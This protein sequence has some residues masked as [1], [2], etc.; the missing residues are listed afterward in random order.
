M[1]SHGW[2]FADSARDLDI[3]GCRMVAGLL[4]AFR[5]ADDSAR[6]PASKP[7]HFVPRL[8]NVGHTSGSVTEGRETSSG[9]VQHYVPGFTEP[10]LVLVPRTKYRH[11]SASVRCLTRHFPPAPFAVAPATQIAS[12]ART[13]GCSRSFRRSQIAE[14]GMDS[15]DTP[16]E[17]RLAPYGRG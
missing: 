2:P 13:A 6:C 4:H 12:A 17:N 9:Q 15:A 1:V 8:G 5:L 16:V 7:R 10:T 3:A 11:G 14:T